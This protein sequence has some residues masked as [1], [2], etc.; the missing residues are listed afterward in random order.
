MPFPQF[1]GYVLKVH[2]KSPLASSH[3]NP[4]ED[5]SV[6]E[7]VRQLFSCHNDDKGSVRF[8]FSECMY[9]PSCLKYQEVFN[10]PIIVP[11][12]TYARKANNRQKC[13]PYLPE[14]LCT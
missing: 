11:M 8:F 7:R 10:G 4:P 12:D 13:C 3:E 6:L 14:K 5:L 1:T 9:L 2:N